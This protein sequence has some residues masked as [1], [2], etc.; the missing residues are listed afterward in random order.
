MYKHPTL[1]QEE[2]N[3]LARYVHYVYVENRDMTWLTMDNINEAVEKYSTELSERND[4]NY[5]FGGG[6]TLDRER[7]F[8][9]LE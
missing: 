7:V 3:E 6:D 5:T 8:V 9:Y 4:P 2:K 1:T